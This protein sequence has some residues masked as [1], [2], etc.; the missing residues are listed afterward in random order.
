MALNQNLIDFRLTISQLNQHIQFA[1]KKYANGSYKITTNLREFI[2][3][4]AFLK[5]FIAWETF[6]E[7]CFIDYLINE[8]S[9]LNR[10]PAKWA[11][12]IDSDHANQLIVGN[13]KHMDWSNPEA[14]RKISK[15]FFHQGY[16]FDTALSSINGDLMDMK[17][18][19][20]SAAHLSSTTTT[21]LDGVATRILSI[22][23]VNFTAY[24]LL[25][26]NDPRIT[27][28]TQTVLERYLNLLDI[29][30]EEIANG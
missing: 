9:V 25:F 4:S 13:Q 10:R 8:E 18:I 19:R 5:M 3:E 1:H 22:P 16:V 6:V 24:R 27:T 17:A 30:A 23:S 7:K 20:N 15:I 29:A 28:A 11:N 21:K 12:P 2:S 14:I 26:H